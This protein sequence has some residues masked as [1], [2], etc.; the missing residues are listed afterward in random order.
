MKILTTFSLA[1]VILSLS[2]AACSENDNGGQNGEPPPETAT[3]YTVP[4]DTT[5]P[6][7]IAYDVTN[8]TLYTGS[9]TNGQLYA[10]NRSDTELSN[11]SVSTSAALGM[12]VAEGQLWVAGGESGSLYR[13]SLS[14]NTVTE[15]SAPTP[16]SADS[17]LLNDVTLAGDGYAYITDSY[18]P[19][20]FRIAI[21]GSG[22]LEPWLELDNTPIQYASG[23]NLNGLAATPDGRY[24]LTV[25]TNTG[26]L[27]RIDLSTQEVTEV[28]ISGGDLSNG[29]GIDLAEGTLYVAQNLTGQVA[30]VQ[31][32]DDYSSGEIMRTIQRDF[33][34]PTAVT[35]AGDNLLVLNSQLDRRNAGQPA[36]LPFTISTVAI[37]N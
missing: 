10:G 21:D 12:E 8:G 32:S 2:G 35:V 36:N 25:Q 24:L 9:S 15:L 37:T 30:V 28:T 26:Q 34:M 33:Q 1:A 22:S 27:F 3:D 20:L 14:D 31:L 17:T 7:G 13:V 23:F 29:D 11:L 16:E 18:R 19:V 5:F 6:E 4:G